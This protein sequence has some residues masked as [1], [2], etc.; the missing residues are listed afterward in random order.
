[1]R[2]QAPHRQEERP[3]GGMAALG[4]FICDD[5]HRLISA[6]LRTPS[7]RLGL[8]EDFLHAVELIVV[9]HRR[10]MQHMRQ[11]GIVVL[12]LH[13]GLLPRVKVSIPAAEQ[14][15]GYGDPHEEKVE[16]LPG[17]REDALVHELGRPGREEG[18]ECDD[19]GEEDGLVK[20]TGIE[21][22]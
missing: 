4:A 20:V 3:A 14:A 10:T 5:N 7:P 11:V 1:M 22:S 13:Q 15:V 12:R 9:E 18:D 16:E 21:F 6:V 8:A 19:H 2:L 17:P